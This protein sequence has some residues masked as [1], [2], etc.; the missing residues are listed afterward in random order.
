VP[1]GFGRANLAGMNDPRAVFGFPNV[2]DETFRAYEPRFRA[3]DKLQALSSELVS[4]TNDHKQK[5]VNILNVLTQIST[6]SMTD[7]VIL[8]GN[9]RD[10]SAMKIARSMF[11]VDII[12]GYLEKNPQEVDAYSEFSLVQTWRYME[13][14]E[15][16]SPGG[17]PPEFK[18]QA[19]A[20]Y[21]RVKARFTDAKGRIW[22][23]FSGKSIRAMAKEL[24]RLDH[25]ETAYSA[26]SDLH[27]MSF[28]GIIGHELDWSREALDVAHGSLL[29]TVASLYN[30]SL[31][32]GFHEK[33]TVAITE[34]NS[35]RKQS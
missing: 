12:A 26:A 33:L 32:A 8:I 13:N 20:E 35:V 9:K 16:H 15:R 29:Q 19:E 11:E 1:S 17:I 31:P 34:F 10:A 4:A 5:L 27:H 22:N 30:V 3:I 24:V 14:S 25:Y 28:V 2:W 21:N 18:K 6:R 7:I 23:T